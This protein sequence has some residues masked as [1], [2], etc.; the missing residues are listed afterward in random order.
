MNYNLSSSRMQKQSTL[1]ALKSLLKLISGEKRNLLLASLAILTNAT[2]S[3]SGPFFIGYTIDTY[4]QTKQYNGVLLFTGIL[5][6]M[7]LVGLIAS[8]LQT[9]LMGTV[10]QRTLYTLRNAIFNKLQQLPVAFFNQNR[11]GDLISR[12]N[13][14]TDKLNQFFSQSLLQFVSSIVTM[15]GAGIFLL[16]INIRLGLAALVPG[17]IIFIFTRSLSPWVR[18]KNALKLK[19]VGGMSAENSG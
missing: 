12:I 1:L 9:K 6:L 7:Y 15:T 4:I 17:L 19:T 16:F 18:Q 8:Y 2:I 13:S 11:A 10:G 5:L 14:D 3:L